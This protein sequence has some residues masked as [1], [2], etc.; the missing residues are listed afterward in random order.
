MLKRQAGYLLL[1]GS[2]CVSSKYHKYAFEEITTCFMSLYIFCKRELKMTLER[3]IE[4]SGTLYLENE[5]RPTSRA[6]W[7]L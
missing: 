1:L 5:R 4:K 3:L 6:G 7:K 2:G